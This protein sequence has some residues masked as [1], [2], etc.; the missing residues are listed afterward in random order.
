MAVAV[1]V[2][3]FYKSYTTNINNSNNMLSNASTVIVDDASGFIVGAIVSIENEQ[4]KITAINS[5]TLTVARAQNGT[6]AAQHNDNTAV[7][8]GWVEALK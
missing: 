3:E 1:P 5:N 2:R 8:Q 6:S 4:V 7:V